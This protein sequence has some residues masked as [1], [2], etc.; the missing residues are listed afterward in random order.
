MIY[1]IYIYKDYFTNSL[2]MVPINDK[3]QGQGLVERCLSIHLQTPPIEVKQLLAKG[4]DV[5]LGKTF[6]EVFLNPKW[7]DAT[8]MGL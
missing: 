6:L 4:S 7:I 3:R 2:R 1:Y 8:G 5:R